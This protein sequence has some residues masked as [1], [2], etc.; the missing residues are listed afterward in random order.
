MTNINRSP[1][2]AEGQATTAPEQKHQLNV[3]GVPMTALIQELPPR[4]KRTTPKVIC[5]VVLDW[6]SPDPT[7]PLKKAFSPEAVNAIIAAEL[8]DHFDDAADESRNEDGS[9]DLT[10]FTIK[11][12]DQFQ[13]GG[14]TK[15]KE[16][17]KKFREVSSELTP[18]W[19]KKTNNTATAEE[20][21]KF[22]RLFA[23]WQDLNVK[24]EEKN[25]TGEKKGK[26]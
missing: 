7:A 14:K 21:V 16:L 13:R 4:G 15:K 3:R 25:R 12:G 24:I 1:D 5:R 10:K 20:S 26:K 2:A 6:N 23:E 8:N 19:V 22:A 11:L 17:E 18:L 9:I